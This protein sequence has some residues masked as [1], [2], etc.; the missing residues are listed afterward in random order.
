MIALIDYGMGNLHSVAKALE[1]AGGSDIRLAKTADEM[2]NADRI[3]LPGVGAFRDCIGAL[4]KTGLDEAIRTQIAKGTPY[5]GICLGMQ[6][7]M[8]VSLEFGRYQGLGL[9]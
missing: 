1:K 9:I 2:A 8:D 5:L 7:L 6:V 4:E 3:V